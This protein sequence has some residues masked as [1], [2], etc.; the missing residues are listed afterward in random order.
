MT[1]ALLFWGL[2]LL[3]GGFAAAYGGRA[4]RHIALIYF[5]ACVATSWVTRD[6]LAW[7]HPHYPAF[8]VDLALLGA[9]SWVALRS[10]R[11]FPIWFTG[12]H[13]VAV[14]SHLASIIAPGFSPRVYFLV[15]AVWSIPML[16]T[17][18]TGVALDRRAGIADAPLGARA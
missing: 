12:L 6:N 14:T 2:V 3:C 1:V 5:A 13:L 7:L 17:L 11:W 4:G 8:G 9:L 15:Q 18:A 10:D 16:A